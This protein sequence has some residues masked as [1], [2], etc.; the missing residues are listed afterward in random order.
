MLSQSAA[1]N[2]WLAC[3]ALHSMSALHTHHVD[4]AQHGNL[5]YAMLDNPTEVSTPIDLTQHDEMRYIV[6][7]NPTAVTIPTT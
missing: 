1:G 2:A 5:F 4:P 7:D 6:V 3:I